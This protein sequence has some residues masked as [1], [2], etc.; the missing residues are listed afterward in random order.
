MVEACKQCSG[1][2]ST[3]YLSIWCWS[4][5][6]SYHSLFP[7]F[8]PS[9]GPKWPSKAFTFSHGCG[10]GFGFWSGSGLCLSLWC[11]SVSVSSFP[12]WCG[13]GSATLRVKQLIFDILKFSFLFMKI[14]RQQAANTCHRGNGSCDADGA[15]LQTEDCTLLTQKFSYSRVFSCQDPWK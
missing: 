1:C 7:R 13:F 9:N 14:D 2:G 11:G 3:S 6:E 10:C 12:F 15:L 5:S 4:G 8:G